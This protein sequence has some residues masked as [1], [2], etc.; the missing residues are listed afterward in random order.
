[1]ELYDNIN[2]KI[3][4][5]A[6]VKCGRCAHI[7]VNVVTNPSG[8]HTKATCEKCGFYL[9]FLSKSEGQLLRKPFEDRK[10]NRAPFRVVCATKREG[11]GILCIPTG[12]FDSDDAATAEVDR[13]KRK[14][15]GTVNDRIASVFEGMRRC[16]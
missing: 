10:G 8:P 14:G 3:A 7:S 16:H 2:R 15:Y 9:R 6:P 1:M 4:L 11:M 12:A 5:P 13:L